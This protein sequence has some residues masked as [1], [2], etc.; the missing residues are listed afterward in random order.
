ME[1][2]EKL[3]EEKKKKEEDPCM[4]ASASVKYTETKQD[5]YIGRGE[6]LTTGDAAHKLRMISRLFNGDVEEE[7]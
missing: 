4:G 2:A 6:C 1:E 5:I 3:E 7:D